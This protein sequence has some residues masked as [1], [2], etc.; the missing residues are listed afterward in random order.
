MNVDALIKLSQE[1]Q[2]IS[3]QAKDKLDLVLINKDISDEDKNKVKQAQE[4]FS[5]LQVAIENKD[6]NKMNKLLEDVSK[7]NI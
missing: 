7:I 3:K 2:D 4:I 5:E 6:I 1:V